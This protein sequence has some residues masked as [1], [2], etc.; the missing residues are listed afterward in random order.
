[1]AAIGSQSTGS[2]LLPQPASAKAT[3]KRP[4]IPFFLDIVMFRLAS[5]ASMADAWTRVRNTPLWA[6]WEQGRSGWNAVIQP[7]RIGGD[8]AVVDETERE[9]T[10]PVQSPMTTVLLVSD[11]TCGAVAVSWYAPPLVK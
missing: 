2:S 5:W 9:R 4:A 8:G 3:S 7:L 6:S 10:S 1:V 11:V